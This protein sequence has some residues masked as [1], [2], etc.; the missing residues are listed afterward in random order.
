LNHR[1]DVEA[2]VLANEAGA[3]LREFFRGRR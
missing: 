1:L 3:L 2:G